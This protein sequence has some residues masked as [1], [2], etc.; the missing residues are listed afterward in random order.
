MATGNSIRRIRDE[1]LV[2]AQ[3]ARPGW[4]FG[5][6]RLP[7]VGEDVFCTGGEGKVVA[8]LGKCGDGSR[9]VQIQLSDP[10]ARPFFAAASNI[11][12]APA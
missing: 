5:S 12:L 1:D 11:L 6:E 2:V 9:L 10:T 8:L 3:A 4:V 7:S